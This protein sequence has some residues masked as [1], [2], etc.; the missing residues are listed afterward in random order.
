[1]TAPAV[2]SSPPPSG[3]RFSAETV[4]FIG[5]KAR[6]ALASNYTRGADH[7]AL[8]VTI[9]GVFDF[10]VGRPSEEDARAIALAQC[11]Q[12]ADEMQPR[13]PCELYAVGDVVVYPHGRPPLPP[14]PWVRH[15]AVTERPFAAKDIPLVRDA[16]KSRLETAYAPARKSRSIAIGP[17]GQFFFNVGAESVDESVRRSLEYCGAF[18]GA[19]CMIVAVDDVFV[20]PL[21]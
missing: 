10:V 5:D 18:V 15:D 7:R 9:S 3:E 17:G 12:H 8:A 20:V 1:G 2:A 13:R 16:G 21:P 6:L 19:A 11:Q 4:P 14:M